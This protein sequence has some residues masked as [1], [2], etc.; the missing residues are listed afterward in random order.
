MSH[1]NYGVNFQAESGHH[2]GG[3]K[4]SSLGRKSQQ[5][6]GERSGRIIS[7]GHQGTV[8]WYNAEK[9]YGFIKLEDGSPDVFVHSS[10]VVHTGLD[11]LREGQPLTFDL[12]YARRNE[13][14]RYAAV[15]L[16][17]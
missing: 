2:S 3:R 13:K 12:E 1:R 15:N 4:T 10:A 8:K 14:D 11:L 9:G 17:L 5:T 16:K 6:A 7:T